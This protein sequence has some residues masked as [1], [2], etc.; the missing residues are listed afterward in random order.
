MA[1]Y[2]TDGGIQFFITH[3]TVVIAALRKR[4]HDIDTVCLRII[5]AVDSV[6]RLSPF[7]LVYRFRVFF[8]G[9]RETETKCL[10]L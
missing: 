5:E 3:L 10:T 7:C 4:S 9:L 1:D 2:G 6:R 8:D